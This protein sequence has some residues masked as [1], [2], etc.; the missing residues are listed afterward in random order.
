MNGAQ[1]EIAAGGGGGGDED[2]NQPLNMSWPD[3]WRERITYVVILPIILPLW[4]TLP[5]TRKTSGY[6]EQSRQQIAN[7]RCS[8]AE[9]Q[10][11]HHLA[12]P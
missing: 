5:D 2:D 6:T 4:L 11:H 12:I 9:T 8:S 7:D 3:S 1:I 10:H